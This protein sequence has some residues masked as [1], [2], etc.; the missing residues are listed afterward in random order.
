[1]RVSQAAPESGWSSGHVVSGMV[2]ISV[3]ASSVGV[4]A[5]VLEVEL[6]QA[7]TSTKRTDIRGTV[8][9]RVE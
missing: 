5:S 6:P 4:L 2:H 9:P 3:L 8:R 7:P 1:M